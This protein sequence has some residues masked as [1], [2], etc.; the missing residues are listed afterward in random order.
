MTVRND[1]KMTVR[2]LAIKKVSASILAFLTAVL[3]SEGEK[4]LF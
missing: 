4:G 2:K 3:A 1:C